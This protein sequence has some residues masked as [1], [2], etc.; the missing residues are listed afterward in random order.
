[1]IDKVQ[2]IRLKCNLVQACILLFCSAYKEGVDEENIIA[3]L[4]LEKTFVHNFLE[5]IP[6]LLVEEKPGFYKF[7]WEYEST[8]NLIDLDSKALEEKTVTNKIFQDR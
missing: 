7:N 3:E 4:T 8:E 1:M 5:Q 2:K 6:Q